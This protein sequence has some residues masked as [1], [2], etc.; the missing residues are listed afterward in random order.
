MNTTSAETVLLL[1]AAP[2][3]LKSVDISLFAI[4]LENRMGDDE[5]V[6]LVE[7]FV[8]WSISYKTI[9]YVKILVYKVNH[10]NF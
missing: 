1:L 7:F 9:Q 10:I 2:L 3:A 5:V 8:T 6:P 4:T